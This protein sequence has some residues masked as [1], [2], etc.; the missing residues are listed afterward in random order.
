MSGG[1]K[2]FFGRVEEQGHC[3]VIIVNAYCCVVSGI[4]DRRVDGNGE[5]TWRHFF[6]CLIEMHYILYI[7]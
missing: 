3:F 5:L 1:W 2:A 4:C 6:K 7:E